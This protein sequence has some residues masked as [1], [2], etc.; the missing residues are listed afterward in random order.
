[1]P[2]PEEGQ[3]PQAGEALSM[4]VAGDFLAR[5]LPALPGDR[6][7]IGMDDEHQRVTLTSGQVR[8][9]IA[10]VDGTD[11]DKSLTRLLEAPASGSVVV[12]RL[13]ARDAVRA[14]LKIGKAAG[15][16]KAQVNVVI[17]VDVLRFEPIL[18]H[19]PH[20]LRIPLA[21]REYGEPRT[22]N[23]FDGKLLL[24]ALNACPGDYV[25][26]SPVQ[27]A[28]QVLFTEAVDTATTGQGYLHLVCNLHKPET[29][30][31]IYETAPAT[32]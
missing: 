11:M 29:D 10:L 17:D 26:I 3:T 13:R 28:K 6:V 12:D 14:A 22:R 15:Q 8:V 9:S 19:R 16:P 21:I 1:M 30:A 23:A 32:D 18:E 7:A 5:A 20:A 25:A 2:E 4:L 31:E 27:S 24:D